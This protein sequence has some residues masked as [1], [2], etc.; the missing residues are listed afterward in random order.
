VL[1]EIR[2]RILRLRRAALFH[3]SFEHVR[4]EGFEP[5]S[6]ALEVRLPSNRRG[7]VARGAGLEPAVSWLTA[8]C[9]A[10]SPP[11]YE[12]PPPESNR[13]SAVYKTAASPAMLD[14]HVRGPGARSNLSGPLEKSNL[15]RPDLCR[16]LQ[17]LSYGEER[18]PRPPGN[19]STVRESNSPHRFGRPGP[20]RSDNGAC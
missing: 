7:R 18:A 10:A 14:G 9:V 12:S 8:S 16:V 1:G 3:L 17:P 11:T 13:V 2:T 4:P 6:T 5:S 20:N 19:V 15:R